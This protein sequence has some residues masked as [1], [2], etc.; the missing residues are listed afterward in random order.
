MSLRFVLAGFVLAGW[1]LSTS[2]HAQ[3]D[4]ETRNAARAL[5]IQGR[6]AFKAQDYETTVDLMRR[7][8]DLVG[9]PTVAVFEARA[10]VKLGRLVEAAEAYRRAIRTPIADDSPAAYQ[11]AMSSARAELSELRPRIPKLKVTIEGPGAQEPGL[12][13]RMDGKPVPPAL[14]G[15][16]RPVDPGD[17]KV[18]AATP[19]GHGASTTRT[20]AEGATEEVTL[21]LAAGQAPF[22]VAAMASPGDEAAASGATPTSASA[23]AGTMADTGATPGRTQRIFAYTSLGV[24][25]AGLGVGLATGL[26]ALDRLDSAKKECPTRV[27]AEDSKAQDDYDSFKTFRTVSTTGYVVGIVG[28]AAGVTLWLTAPRKTEGAT[29]GAYVTPG[30][31]GVKGVF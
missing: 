3:V 10:L 7:A 15:V 23:S 4:D 31:A 20:L 11:Q 9:A 5:A 26:V 19:S 22:A 13:V 25:V 30:S 24:G 2:A 28:V 17:R 16:A 27:C 1:L 14:L 8:Y 21:T 29:V 18:E 6:D 12:E